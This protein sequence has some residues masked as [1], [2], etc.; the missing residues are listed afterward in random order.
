MYFKYLS[1]ITLAIFLSGCGPSEEE[2]RA[3]INEEMKVKAAQEA[4]K[5][6]LEKEQANAKLV[7]NWKKVVSDVEIMQLSDDPNAKPI[8]DGITTYMLDNDKGILF[9]EFQYEMIGL[10][11]FGMFRETLGIPDYIVEK[12]SQTRPIDGTKETKYENVEISWTVSRSSG[13]ISKIKLRTQ[14]RLVD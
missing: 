5:A 10:A 1:V 9:E 13:P 2:I 12:I 11:G 14:L 7:R 4:E 6:R 8:G 3:K